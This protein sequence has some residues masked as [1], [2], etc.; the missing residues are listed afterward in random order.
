MAK[1][2]GATWGT[3]EKGYPVVL[4]DFNTQTIN[5]DTWVIPEVTDGVDVLGNA[6]TVERG[7]GLNIPPGVYGDFTEITLNK[8]AATIIFKVYVREE[9]EDQTGEQ[10][11]FLSNG[12][13]DSNACYLDF[14]TGEILIT[15][16]NSGTHYNAVMQALTGGWHTIAIVVDDSEAKTYIDG[17]LKETY[18]VED[19]ITFSELVSSAAQKLNAVFDYV[20]L[21]NKALS[22]TERNLIGG[23]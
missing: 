6:I 13:T 2:N 19:N 22:E 4:T 5:D 3:S 8:S 21:S 14:S 1:I 17:T 9:V 7:N 23:L 10:N 15:K 18:T 12:S 16:G 11:A 20:I